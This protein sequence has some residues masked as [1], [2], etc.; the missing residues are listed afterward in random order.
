VNK[1]NLFQT[2]RIWD[3]I[4][5]KVYHLVDKEHKKGKAQNGELVFNLEKRIAKMFNRKYCI[6]FSCCTDALTASL[7]TLDL[8][9][10]SKVGLSNYTFTAT[11][12]SIKNAGYLPIALDVNDMYVLPHN[13]NEDLKAIVP[14]DIFGNMTDISNYNIPV[15]MD[16]AQSLE[17][18]DG[19]SF[20]ASKGIASCISFSPSKTISSWGSGGAVLT[21][22]S[23][24]ANKLYKL[25][26][27]GK[28]NN[29]EHSIH[30]GFNSMMSSFEA[31][32]VW[33]G[34]DFADDWQK[35]RLLIA[36]Y[37]VQNS[38]YN[39]AVDLSQPKH[40]LHKLVFQSNERNKVI[41]KFIKNGVDAVCHYNILI[42]QEHLY[43]NDKC[44]N[45][46]RLQSISFTV[47][48]QH[49]LTDVEVEKI[50]ELLK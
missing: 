39:S 26:L 20:S 34:L 28:Q 15:I 30:A 22:D 17:S 47:P 43:K 33:V 18:H 42:N 29:N 7:I 50:G 2:E 10:N 35:R 37:L 36:N 4:K 48:N 3:D 45:S 25:R 6:T 5:D 14:V 16:A 1:I 12:N 8:P 11:A 21:D 27:H 41:D 46:E 38:Q 13:I 19:K 44:P 24:I 40:T 49:T 31:S 23:D 32:C 9:K